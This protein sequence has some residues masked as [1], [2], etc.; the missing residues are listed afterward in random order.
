MTSPP[1]CRPPPLHEW[2][3][4]IE[5]RVAGFYGMRGA[6]RGYV[7]WRAVYHRRW[8][9][10]TR[11]NPNGVYFLGINTKLGY[12]FCQFDAYDEAASLNARGPP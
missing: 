10:A 3:G 12:F 2:R 9:G 4:G 5:A 6:R 7:G 11:G 8:G 1:A